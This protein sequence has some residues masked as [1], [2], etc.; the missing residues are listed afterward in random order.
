MARIPS[1][2]TGIDTAAGGSAST[3]SRNQGPAG[4]RRD[5]GDHERAVDERT[6]PFGVF[7]AATGVN[8]LVGLGLAAPLF[9]GYT[10]AT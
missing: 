3:R 1:R 2:N 6:G 5:Q 10:P 7:A 8:P 4:E 9:S